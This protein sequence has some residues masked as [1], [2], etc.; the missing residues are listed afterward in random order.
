MARR[1]APQKRN[2]LLEMSISA[3]ALAW[4][5]DEVEEI[6]AA[7]EQSNLDELPP[8]LG[9][10]WARSLDCISRCCFGMTFCDAAGLSGVQR[11]A[12]ESPF[13]ERP[14][15]LSKTIVLLGRPGRTRLELSS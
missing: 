15:D 8:D 1:V 6:L 10:R 11:R 2:L 12:H 4:T 3:M 9:R 7:A 5:P 13:S 14:A